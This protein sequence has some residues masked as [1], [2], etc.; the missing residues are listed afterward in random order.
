MKRLLIIIILCLTA[1]ELAVYVAPP[2][3]VPVVDECDLFDEAVECIKSFE[4][5]HSAQHHPYVGY[6]HRL[7]PG[8]KFTADIS[9]HIADS[10]LR[11]DLLQ[12]CAVFRGFG[13][14][15]LLLGVLAYNIGETRLLKSKLIEKLRSGDRDII[16][17][18]TSFRMYRGKVVASLERRRKAEFELLFNN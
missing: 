6:G 15:S 18:Y 17:E 7:M 3:R 16:E 13:R 11:G 8:E 9:E 2:V 1:G 14:D 4:G 10:I 12:K 5:W